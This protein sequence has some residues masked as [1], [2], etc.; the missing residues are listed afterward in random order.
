[1]QFEDKSH[2]WITPREGEGEGWI[3]VFKIIWDDILQMLTTTLFFQLFWIFFFNSI[4]K[5]ANHKQ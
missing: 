4:N 1:M 2:L 5:Q 3:G